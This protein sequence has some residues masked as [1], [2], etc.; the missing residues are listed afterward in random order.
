MK[1]CIVIALVSLYGSMLY[2]K[3]ENTA[4]ELP[5]CQKVGDECQLC[6]CFVNGIAP[7]CGCK[8]GTC[9]TV[10]GQSGNLVCDVGQRDLAD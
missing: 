5:T 7:V 3:T 2:A 1:K 9:T 8:E 6:A 10:P 4:N